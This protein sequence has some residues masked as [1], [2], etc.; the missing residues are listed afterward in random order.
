MCVC[1][2]G[3]TLWCVSR[4]SSLLL[5]VVCWQGGYACRCSRCC[6]PLC[7]GRAPPC[8]CSCCCVVL[9]G[10]LAGCRGAHHTHTRN[11]SR[12]CCRLR[13][14]GA[15]GQPATTKQNGE[16]HRGGSVCQHQCIW[17]SAG[18][19]GCWRV[20]GRVVS[21]VSS[22]HACQARNSRLPWHHITAVGARSASQA[23]RGRKRWVCPQSY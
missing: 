1:G 6:A 20:S 14:L 17:C 11:Q 3:C 21:P 18:P 16:Q 22:M 9:C 12:R 2:G 23:Q 19:S 4:S 10:A 13:L 8:C 5:L 15:A 7:A